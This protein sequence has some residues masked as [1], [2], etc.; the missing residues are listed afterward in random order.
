MDNFIIK[1]D[2]KTLFILNG[3]RNE[4]FPQEERG[5]MDRH[6]INTDLNRIRNYFDQHPRVK[7]FAL[8]HLK[9][10]EPKNAEI[11]I[12]SFLLLS[13]PLQIL[14]IK[15]LKSRVTRDEVDELISNVNKKDFNI[16]TV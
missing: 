6:A 3:R 1:F 4:D 10:F 16:V 5:N 13:K 11:K 7:E 2:S 15:L 12:K 9:I 14:A 8:E